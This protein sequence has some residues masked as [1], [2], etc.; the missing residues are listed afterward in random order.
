MAAA[1]RLSEKAETLLRRRG[2]NIHFIGGTALSSTSVVGMQALVNTVRDVSGRIELCKAVEE[3]IRAVER[4]WTITFGFIHE[5]AE[6]DFVIDTDYF[7]IDGAN[8][9]GMDAAANHA[10]CEEWV[11]AN[12]ETLVGQIWIATPKYIPDGEQDYVDTLLPWMAKTNFFDAEFMRAKLQ[13]TREKVDN[14]LEQV[15]A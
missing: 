5:V 4:S 10:I 12:Q 8:A 11:K 15:N 1:K 6:D 9:Y 13:S 2:N 7:F 14:H 3:R